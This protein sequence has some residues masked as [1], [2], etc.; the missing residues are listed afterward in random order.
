MEIWLTKDGR[1]LMRFFNR[2][3][4]AEN[5]NYEIKGMNPSD[6]PRDAITPRTWIPGCIAEAFYNW[7]ISE[8][9]FFISMNDLYNFVKKEKADRRTEA[10]NR[11]DGW[12]KVL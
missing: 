2:C 8:M 3:G 6:I 5:I 7:M 9:P 11:M 10:D 12:I 1:L 4:D